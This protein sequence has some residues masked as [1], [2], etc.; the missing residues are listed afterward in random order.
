MGVFFA[1]PVL[2]SPY[3][4]PS[5]H[6][7]LDAEGQ[8]TDMIMA[9]RRRSDLVTPVPKPKRRKGA[10]TEMVLDSGDGLST[11]EQEYNPTPIIN[12][13]RHHVDDWRNLKNPDQWLVTPQTA[14]LLRH[15]RAHP[16]QS[17]RPFF[18]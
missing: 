16:F 18:C 6:W 15:W 17:I 8:P 7:Q 12:E 3:G 11:L 5:R 10:Q 1:R 9:A 13:I 4:V 2:N 14:R